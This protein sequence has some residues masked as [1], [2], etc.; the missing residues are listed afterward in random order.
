LEQNYLIREA[1]SVINVGKSSM[2]KWVRQLKN[3]RQRTSNHPTA[4]T[5]DQRK[6]KELE[7]TI[8]RIEMEKKY[9]KRLPLS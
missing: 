7:K 1:A 4:I 9:K 5:A 6:I 3:K 2:D 8:K